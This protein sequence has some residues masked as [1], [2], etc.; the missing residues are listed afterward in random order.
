M[1]ALE[2]TSKLISRVDI[3]IVG[4]AVRL[5]GSDSVLE[6]I[7]DREIAY[8][9]SGTRLKIL[10]NI[11]KQDVGSIHLENM[12]Q[13]DVVELPRW[14]GEILTALGMA[15]SQEESFATEVFKAVNREKM[16]GENQIAAL[17]SDFYLK[18]RRHVAFST[19]MSSLKPSMASELDRTRTLIYDLVALRLRKILLISSALSPPGDMREKLTPEEYQIFDTIYGLLQSWRAAIMGGG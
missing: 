13:G 10:Q 18:V 1:S 19:E 3:W 11:S 6:S 15:E 7:K 8:L 4:I 17:R 14:V 16:A 5:P 2:F 12:N 9:L